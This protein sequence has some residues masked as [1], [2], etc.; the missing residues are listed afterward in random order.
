[1]FFAQWTNG[2]STRLEADEAETL[3]D[4]SWRTEK[5]NMT[6]LDT[7]KT[8]MVVDDGE[9]E[10][11][12]PTMVQSDKEK[13]MSNYCEVGVTMEEL[14]LAKFD[15]VEEA[16]ARYVEYTWVTTFAVRKG[17]SEKEDEGTVV[18]K[19]F[20]Y[21]RQ[22]LWDRNIMRGLIESGHTNQQYEGTVMRGVLD[23]MRQ[24][25]PM[26]MVTDGNKS[27]KEAIQSE[28]PN[29]THQLCCWHLARN[30]VSNIKDANFVV[31]SRL[32]CMK[33]IGWRWLRALFYAEVRTTS[34]C[35]G[36]K[37]SLKKFIRSGNCLLE[38]VEYLDR[39]V[40]DYRNNEFMANF[41][42]L[43]YEPM[44]TTWLESIKNV[45]SKVYTREIFFKVKKQIWVVAVLIMLHNESYGS[46][47]KF[48]LR[49]F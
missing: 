8:G 35:E 7:K 6:S 27:M 48:M 10:G 34:R 21:N 40:K 19:L 38:L 5:V 31:H 20:Y 30:A 41:K 39:V 14:A 28:F 44:M 46:I 43:Y 9:P 2:W 47:E 12:S 4:E 25:E 49:K 17:D 22:G 32:R 16:Y 36:I 3:G 24:K 33:T 13:N 29:A 42:S 1:M 11:S 37:S 18:R 23:I 15:S 45:V 26:V